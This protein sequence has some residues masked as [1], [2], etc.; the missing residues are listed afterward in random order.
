MDYKED[1]SPDELIAIVG[2]DGRFPGAKNITEFWQNISNGVKSISFFSDEELLAAGV[3]PEVF[4]A[5]NYVKAGVILEDADLFD[6]PFFGFTPREAETMDPQTRLFLQ[7]VW[8]ALEDAA[9]D[10]GTYDGLIGVFAGKGPSNYLSFNLSTH[11]DLLELVGN[12]QVESG[13]YSDALSTMVA[14]KLDLKGP[15]VSVQTFCS[16]SMVALHLA[17]QSLLSYECDMAVAGGVAYAYPEG[18]GYLYQDGGVLSPDGECRTFDARGQGTVVGS[19]VGVVVVKRLADALEQGDQ[20]YA[21]IR[22]SAVNNDGITRVSYA[23]PGLNG[24]ARV[25][26][27][28]MGNANVEPETISYVEAH[29]TGTTMGDAVEM[30]ALIEVFQQSTDKTQFCALGSVKP[31]VGHLDRASGVTGLIKTIMA[32]KHK[33]LPPSLNFERTSSDIDLERSAFFVNTELRSWEAS[34]SLPRRAGVNSFGMG[35]TNTHV[36]LEEAPLVPPSSPS[37]P[38][39]LLLF[40]AKTESALELMTSNLATFLQENATI[41]LADGAYTLQVGRAR[42]N[43]RR[44]VVC[45]DQEDAAS[46]LDMADPRRVFTAH[47]SH[48]SRS[49]VF[50]FPGV[51]DHY[52]SMAQDLYQTEPIFK[53]HL[54]HCCELL[55]PYIDLDLRDILYQEQDRPVPTQSGPDLRR[56][57]GRDQNSDTNHPL[58]QTALAQPAV[59]AIEY[60]LAQLLMSWGIKPAAMIGYSLGE[61]VVACLAGVLSLDD[62]LMVVAKRA[63]MI[64]ALEPGAMLA[65]P[66][67]A[68]K[69]RP[70]LRDEVAV[71]AIIGPNTSILAGPTDALESIEQRLS[72]QDVLCRFLTTTHAFHSPMMLPI[73]DTFADLLRTVTLHPPQIPYLSNVTGTWVSENEV[74]DPTFWTKH[75]CQTVQFSAGLDELLKDETLLFL[76]VGP[77]QSL[78]SFVKQHPACDR[79]QRQHV[80]PTLRHVYD[81]QHDTAFL[82]NT[83][84][85][86]WLAGAQIDWSGFYQHETRRRISLP[87]YPFARLRYWIEPNKDARPRIQPA[88]SAAQSAIGKKVDVGDWFYQPVWQETPLSKVTR[89][90]ANDKWL[91]FTDSSDLGEQLVSHL[92]QEEG[93]AVR[94]AIGDQ[95]AVLENNQFVIRADVPADYSD[96]VYEL[97][98]RN[99]LPQKIVHLWTVTQ[100]NEPQTGAAGF[101]AMQKI[102]Y[103]SLI[104]LVRALSEQNVNE[105]LKMFVVSSNAQPVTGSELLYPEKATMYGVQRAILQECLT[106]ACRMIDLDVP[107][108]GTWLTPKT[109]ELLVA[110]LCTPATDLE[111]AYRDEKR[112]VRTYEAVHLAE[113]TEVPLRTKGAYLITGGLGGVGLI[114]AR[115]LAETMQ[116]NL[117]LTSRHGLPDRSEWEQWLATHSETDITS[118]RIRKVIGIESLGGTVLPLAADVANKAEMAQVLATAK[119]QFGSINGVLHAAGISDNAYASI[120]MITRQQCEMNF[121]PKVYGLYVLEELLADEKDLDFCL[122]FSSISAVLGGIGFVGYSSANIFMDVYTHQHNRTAATNWIS[123]NWDTWQLRADQHTILGKTVAAYDMTPAEGIDAFRR[124]LAHSQAGRLINST[125]DL[126]DR[127]RQWVMLESLQ[128][129][130]ISTDGA[131]S[132]NVRP[133]LATSY[134][135]VSSQYEQKVADVWQKL[136]GIEDIGIHDNFFDL[137]GNSL[138]G[139]QVIAQLK[140]VFD[141]QIPVVALFEAPT[142]ADLARYLRPAQSQKDENAQQKALIERR[143]QA[144]QQVGQQQVAVIGLAG[145]FPG[146]ETV[147]EFW[148]NL[149]EGVESV[150]FFTDDELLEAG[151]PSEVFKSPNYIKARPILQDA[152][153]FDA[154]FFGFSP[155]EAELTDP[156]HRIFL[157]C[158][159]QALETAG[160]DPKT[161]PGLIGLFAGRNISYYLN[162]LI[163]DPEFMN[164]LADYEAAYQLAAGNDK[165]ALATGVAYKLNLKGPTL[166]IQTFCS[167][168]LVATHLACQSLLNGECNIALAGGVSIRVPMKAGYTAVEGGMESPDGHCRTFDA[169]AAGTLF[170]DAAAVV[171]LKR[172][173]DALEDGDYI[174]GCIKGS[175]VNNDGSLKAGF[176]APSVTGQSEVIAAALENAG[177]TADEIGYIEAHGT[178]TPIGDPIEFAALS[179]AFRQTTNAIGYC[180]IGSVKTNM[181]HLDH[182]AGVTGLIKAVLSLKHGLI[183]P[184]LHFETPNPELEIE[185]SPFY[186]NTKLSNWQSNGKPRRAGVSSLGVG[187]TNAHVIVEEPPVKHNSSPSRPSQLV[188]LSARTP[189]ALDKATANLAHYLRQNPH[190][191]LADVAYTLQVGRSAFEHRRF[192]VCTDA[193]DTLSVLESIDP[194]R[195]FNRYQPDINRPVVFMFPGVG[196]HYLNMARELYQLEPVF[197]DT[198]NRCCDILQPILGLDLRTELY[199]PQSGSDETVSSHNGPD[200]RQ[201][202][203]RTDAN[204]IAMSETLRRTEY[205]QPVVFIVEYALSQLLRAWGIVPEALIGYSLGEYTAA[206]LAGVLSLNDALMLVAKRAQLIQHAPI[207]HMVAVSLSEADVQPY[208]NEQ[209]CLAIV[210]GPATSVLAGPA[211]AIAEL[212]AQWTEQGILYRH[213][214]TNHAFHSTMLQPLVT[215]LTN[216]VRRIKLNPPQIPYISNVTGQWITNEEA[217]N[218]DYWAQH[219]CQTVQFDKGLAELFQDPERILLEVGPGQSLGSFAKQHPGCQR[220][221]ISL[222]LPTLRSVFDRQVSDMAFLLG[223]LGKLW[224][225]GI[226][227]DWTGFYGEERRQR[228]PLPTYPFERQSYWI[229]PSPSA[230]YASGT[231][232]LRNDDLSQ[233]FYTPVWNEM[234][235]GDQ[236]GETADSWLVFEDVLNWGTRIGHVLHEKGALVVRVQPGDQFAQLSDHSFTIRPTILADYQMLL[237]TLKTSVGVPTH[238]AHAWSIDSVDLPV[239]ESAAFQAAQQTGFYSLLYLAK[240]LG[241]EGVLDPI[242][243]IILSSNMRSVQD[244]AIRPEKA[245]LAGPALVIQQEYQNVRCRSVDITIPTDSEQETRLVQQ[246]AAEL[247]ASVRDTAVAYRH[248][249]RYVQ[250]FTLEELAAPVTERLQ[251][252]GVYLITGALGVIGLTLAEHLARQYQAR[253]VL[254][255]RSGLPPRADWESLLTD[256]TTSPVICDRIRKV[257]ML[258]TLGAEVMVV[259]AD[260]G[261]EAQMET[262]VQQTYERFGHLHGVIHGAGLTNS[263]YFDVVQTIE[264]RVCEAHFAGKVHGLYVLDKVLTGKK[265]DFCFLLSSVSAVLGGLGYVGY[266]AANAFMDA[267]AQEHN[268]EHDTPW[269]TVNWDTWKEKAD[270]VNAYEMTLEEGV[271]AFEM[272]MGS[273]ILHLVNS[274]GDLQARIRQWVQL[275]RQQKKS[276]GKRKIYARPTLPTTYVPASNEYENRIAS[277]WQDVL[278]I[279]EVGI[280]DNFF[281]LGGNSL[282]GLE[283]IARL[284]QA[285]KIPVT[286]IALF[287]APTVHTLARYL[288]PTMVVEVDTAEAALR[289]RR[290]QARLGLEDQDIAIIAMNGRFPGARNVMQFWKNL[291]EGVESI[292]FFTDEELLASG[293]SQD[294]I[295]KPNYVRARPILEDVDEFDASF[296]GYSP[297]EAELLDPQQRILLECAWEAMELAGYNP[298]IYKG[299]V[300]V[301]AGA[302]FSSYVVRWLVDPVWGA[303]VSNYQ[304][305]ISGADKDSLATTLSYKLDLRGPSFAVQTFCSTSLVAT[306][307]AA[308]SLLNGECDIAL[309]GA[310]SISIPQ[311]Q[312][313]LYEEGGMES[314]DG[315][316]RTFDAEAKGTLFGDGMGLVVLKRLQDAVDDGDT[317][318]AIIKGSAINNDGSLKVGYTAPSVSGQAQA[319]IMALENAGIDPE[320]VGYVEAHGTATELG[321]PIEIASLTR[322]YRKFTDKKGFCGIGSL[323][324]NMG[325]LDRASGIAALIKAVLA[326]KHGVIPPT[327]HFQSP[328]PEIDFE[329][330]PFYVTSEFQE[331]PRKNGTPRRAGVNSLGMGGTNA[332]VIVEEPPMQE[333]SGPSR[334]WQLLLMSARTDAALDAATYNLTHYLRQNPEVN[335]AD[336]AYTLQVGRRSFACRRMVVCKDATDSLE[337]LESV[338]PRRVQSNYQPD[339]SRPLAFMFPGVGD[340]YLHMAKDLYEN[341]PLFHDIVEQCCRI[342]YPYLGIK[343]HDLLYPASEPRVQSSNGSGVNLRAMMRAEKQPLSAATRKLRETAVAQPAVFVIEYALARLLMAWGLR[344]QIMIGYSLGEYVAACI[345]GVLSLEDAL[346]LVAKRAQMIQSLPAGNMLA[347]SLPV[348][349]VQTLLSDEVSLAAHNGQ[350]MCILAGPPHVIEQIETELT[351]QEI[352]CRSLDTTHA[353]H[354]SMMDPLSEELTKLVQTVRLQ[355]PR[356]PYLSNVTGTWITDE[357]ATDPRYWAQHMCQPVRFYDALHNLLADD[358]QVLLEVGPGQSLGSFAKQHPACQREQMRLVLPTMRYSYD[359]RDDQAFLLGTLGEL[360]LLGMQMDWSLFYKDETRRRIPLPTYPFERQ[361]FWIKL[362]AGNPT[363]QAGKVTKV[364]EEQ[365]LPFTDWF[366]A[367]IW[368]QTTPHLPTPPDAAQTE[369]SYWLLFVD[370]LGFGDRVST[371][372]QEHNQPGVL[373][374]PGSS[375]VNMGNNHYQ[376]RPDER[377]DYYAI[378]SEM[379]NQDMNLT[380]IVHFWSVTTD[381]PALSDD[382]FLARKLSLGFY[383]LMALAQALGELDLASCQLSVVTSDIQPVTGIEQICPEKATIIGPCKVIPQEY[384]RMA[385]R[386]IDIEWL[387][388]DS[389]QADELLNN[390]LGELTTPPVDSMVALR[391]HQRWVQ[392]F[393]R[394]KLPSVPDTGPLWLRKHGVYLIT[395]GIGGIGLA[396][397]QYLAQKE[398]VKLVLTSRSGLPPRAEWAE[399]LSRAGDEKGVGRKIRW[400]QELE[401][402]GAEV[403]VLAA[404]VADETQMRSAVQQAVA[405][406]GVIHGVVHTAGIPGIGLIQLKT[407][408]MAADVLAPKVQ[409]TAVLDRIFKEVELDFMACFSS[410]NSITGGGPGQIDYSA[411]NAFMD[412]YAHSYMGHKRV[413]TSIDWGEWQWDAWQEG[414]EGFNPE[415]QK[416]LVANR[417]KYGIDFAEGSQAWVQVVSRRLPQVVVSTRDFLDVVAGSKDF[418]IERLLTFGR[419]DQEVRQKYSRPTLRTSFVAPRNEMEQKIAD[420]WG[421]IL[422]IDGIGV[423][424]NFFDLGGNSLVGLDM[425]ARL[426][427]ELDTKKIPAHVIYEAPSVSELVKFLNED[428][429]EKKVSLAKRLERGEKRR[430]RTVQER[431]RKRTR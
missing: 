97:K 336:V 38:Y 16:T 85:K 174:Y 306:H 158:A 69:L 56:M 250:H 119:E 110:D 419:E 413:V 212:E 234:E 420:L 39:Q 271:Q 190:T 73:V 155:R 405:Q 126:D 381:E 341:E 380:Q 225:A 328:N 120:Q 91:V 412:A 372:L 83:L 289:D 191:N 46:A 9:Y 319:V 242:Q 340:H 93:T 261:N 6:A 265:L 315:H 175:A 98:E 287:E 193:A 290:R 391:R 410:M 215:D 327:L 164:S 89:E 311:K 356:I 339:M 30:A 367:P 209:V 43:H 106:I 364:G 130:V 50:M 280:H 338:D 55:K 11:P 253:L 224:L 76:E 379:Q 425:I 297:R 245:A 80:L 214:E 294:L 41:N 90:T 132:G 332:H 139:L 59:F 359:N 298:D 384:P 101:M 318:H 244:N 374:H 170:G 220:E 194:N 255:S 19:G 396:M 133:D 180:A 205:A 407:P 201:M 134:M 324:T 256:E 31:N 87:T 390:L 96:L 333:P 21:V 406:F 79:E 254:T 388:P 115:H 99:L 370:T 172:L 160:Y 240:A 353:F 177:V 138:I 249:V 176:T 118:L 235:L 182:A 153:L 136:L 186:V 398:P 117:I 385:C 357:Q 292:S 307:L 337:V 331:W 371:W 210:N 330:S 273:G 165:D 263:D 122:L 171:V 68:E 203:G 202:L 102:G 399:I 143:K 207:G 27:A 221:Q 236:D 362:N 329:N 26:A 238:I 431:G 282:V 127:I 108:A 71:A 154:P 67:S 150:S 135:P 386:A 309:A 5:P 232:R 169:R 116:A 114:L 248:G 167:T 323:K 252:G 199:P 295:D 54:D 211:D 360:W 243:L 354:S 166:S 22:G 389:W 183:P 121:Q 156:Q 312:G 284:Q 387:S 424:D 148:Q 267:Y 32:L 233:W 231:T 322:A 272:V 137:G 218:P 204:R 51:G 42:F 196:D 344:P 92:T 4:Q 141:M 325:H 13:N 259:A 70:F 269:I 321:D 146:A 223:T 335:L 197:K 346:K 17:C 393:D 326:V 408:E 351:R 62:A 23:A 348:A 37:R 361:K 334:P 305:L 44:M 123:V 414:L 260:A 308:Q 145:R 342:L 45:H 128:T 314:P 426:K 288:Q 427:K 161:Y 29:G 222:V 317:I 157:E 213:L 373:V 430:Q 404:D 111:V 316:C 188:L 392:S 378:L 88:K 281:D 60:A 168:S 10:P 20:I 25:I 310:V 251:V 64:Q 421:E 299:L 142:V 151:V 400:V 2:M 368:Q 84:G 163:T 274:T 129:D 275:E 365:R 429:S 140:K 36:V 409:G 229:E 192:A 3:D 241:S 40:S 61:Y 74:I 286:P 198:I 383:S 296:F 219:M 247:N 173:E 415:V 112:Y 266:V 395:G 144:R 278:G 228:L 18:T 187:G 276:G 264:E 320:T 75:L 125:G 258:E 35:G 66:L 1:L 184:S 230:L 24:Q 403:L 149:C 195:T 81:Q 147:D 349:D 262:A 343:L 12:T 347:V 394:I 285:F 109:L 189:S 14:Y 185:T 104:Y 131:L 376:I 57:L 72:S 94:V 33:M 237:A 352:S 52:P 65:V 358:E 350:N 226:Q 181:G 178:A 217:T 300:G 418:N 200:L 15:T 423:M 369:N 47:Q 416:A 366:Y 304:V 345:A 162:R 270:T 279:E 277:I 239:E 124:I 302:T 63:A 397:A 216:L 227:P 283:V 422:G 105:H 428:R 95:F 291:C 103:Y 206:C 159:W 355:P 402:Q 293:F 313:H 375:F 363:I 107:A 48:V 268:R 8:K 49:A 208:L 86:A 53:Q 34:H 301:F 377:E 28:A 77:G 179:K 303:S 152:D 246:L 100:E 82:L 382:S 257:Q 401:E 113:P 58:R 411:A 7:C 78:S 417:Q